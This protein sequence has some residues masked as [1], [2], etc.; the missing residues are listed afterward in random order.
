MWS[1]NLESG[2]VPPPIPD[3]PAS[4]CL[5]FAK[6]KVKLGVPPPAIEYA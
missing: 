1:R 5:L 4:F 6:E 2:T 3:I